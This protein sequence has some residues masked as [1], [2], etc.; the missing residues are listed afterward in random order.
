MTIRAAHLQVVLM[1]GATKCDPVTHPTHQGGER[2]R[3]DSGCAWQRSGVGTLIV[4]NRLRSK[5]GSVAG[6]RASA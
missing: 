2:H 6:H 5:T 3:R 4:Q 1:L